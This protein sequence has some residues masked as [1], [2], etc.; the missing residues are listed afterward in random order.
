M[1]I[2]ISL[3][4]HYL[5]ICQQHHRQHCDESLDHISY[6]FAILIHMHH[7]IKESP[8]QDVGKKA[9][10]KAPSEEQPP[11]LEAFV[12]SSSSF[13]NEQ[14]REEKRSQEVE[15]EAV[16]SRQAQDSCGCSG[17]CRNRGAAVVQNSC[18][19]PHRHFTD[20]LWAFT[21]GYNSCHRESRE[22]RESQKSLGY[23]QRFI[24]Y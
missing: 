23:T 12:P 22:V 4:L 5:V 10:N 7:S 16:Q 17:Q 2:N 8:K 15:D 6:I 11:R 21:L 9:P 3:S 18:V 1:N 14:Q 24:D 19:A 20:E 13:E